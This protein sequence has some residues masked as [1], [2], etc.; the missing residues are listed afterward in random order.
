MAS[1]TITATEKDPGT[2]L[3][4]IGHLKCDRTLE[5]RRAYFEEHQQKV[6]T[7]T[8]ALKL[9]DVSRAEIVAQMREY[10]RDLNHHLTAFALEDE[11]RTNKPHTITYIV[12][13]DRPVTGGMKTL[14][15]ANY[16]MEHKTIHLDVAIKMQS[17]PDCGGW[18]WPDISSGTVVQPFRTASSDYSY[19]TIRSSDFMRALGITAGCVCSLYGYC[20]D[21]I[22]DSV[23]PEATRAAFHKAFRASDLD[24]LLSIN[25]GWIASDELGITFPHDLEVCVYTF[26][27]RSTE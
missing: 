13:P 26:T 20:N 15:D 1:F 17:D 12:R 3:L 10:N 19:S 27:P 5:P 9:L 21:M 11:I 6:G 18:T 16:T 2:S 8:V 22:S 25:S 14:L 23:I 24:E 4:Q 7:Q